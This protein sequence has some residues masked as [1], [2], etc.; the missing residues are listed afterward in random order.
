MREYVT[1]QQK[2]NKLERISWTFY[3]GHDGAVLDEW[4]HEKRDSARH[5]YRSGQFEKTRWV[6][7]FTRENRIEKPEVPQ[8]IKEQALAAYSA[9]LKFADCEFNYGD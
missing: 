3:Y 2:I 8:D 7:L 5:S 9:N 6:R 4:R 1:I